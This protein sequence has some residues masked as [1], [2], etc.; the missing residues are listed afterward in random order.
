MSTRNRSSPP[1]NWPTAHRELLSADRR[2]AQAEQ[3]QT[4]A[5]E[6][7]RQTEQNFRGVLDSLPVHTCLL[8]R[9]GKI[10]W[11]N[12]AM[13]EFLGCQLDDLVGRRLWAPAPGF[14]SQPEF[15]A[16]IQ[17]ACELASGGVA[18]GAE[19]ALKTPDGSLS[20]LEFQFA[21]LCAVAGELQ[22]I[23]VSVVDITKR[24]QV[25]RA[26]AEEAIR[27]RIFIEQSRDGIVVLDQQEGNVQEANHRFA[28]MLGYS[29]DELGQ[30][31]VW[32]WDARWTR[33]EVVSMVAQT[34]ETGRC[35]ETRHRRK[36]G[37]L[38][39]V[40]I[41]A[42]AVVHGGRKLVFCV[43]RDISQRKRAEQEIRAIANAS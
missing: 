10:L 24:K 5:E 2:L 30:L 31:H 35:F 13:L 12:R 16:R 6:T 43:C 32:D 39:D 23:V 41:T 7:K 37:S 18:S 28:E 38:L 8:A 19:L 17:K 26:L 20:I 3:D 14:E 42:N 25:E 27:R 33:E 21:P 11:V 1:W 22:F 15:E 9:D 29:L 4:Q 36:D 34:D 40:E